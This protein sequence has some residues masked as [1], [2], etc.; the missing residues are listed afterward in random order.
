VP[1]I[2]ANGTQMRLPTS[3][4]TATP[5]PKDR[6]AAPAPIPEVLVREVKVVTNG[7]APKFGRPRHGLQRHHQSVRTGSPVDRR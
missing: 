5:T 7:F 6:G 1:R 3:E 4:S 2:N